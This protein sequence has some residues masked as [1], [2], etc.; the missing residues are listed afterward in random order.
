MPDLTTVQR[1]ALLTAAEDL[2]GTAEQMR[3]SADTA[4]DYARDWTGASHR[5]VSQ[6]DAD[7]LDLAERVDALATAIATALRGE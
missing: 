7:L 5:D 2:E 4:N 6:V 3:S 1:A